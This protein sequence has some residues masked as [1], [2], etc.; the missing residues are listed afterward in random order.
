MVSLFD[1]DLPAEDQDD[2]ADLLDNLEG[3]S[4]PSEDAELDAIFREDLASI[5][6]SDEIATLDELDLEP[7]SSED[8]ELEA[9]LSES[10][11]TEEPDAEFAFPEITTGGEENPPHD[12]ELEAMF[13]DD[14]R[15]EEPDVEVS[16]IEEPD[17]EITPSEDIELDAVFSDDLLTEGLDVEMPPAEALES[18]ISAAPEPELEDIFSEPSFTEVAP[19]ADAELE[20]M[21]NDVASAKVT[22]TADLDVESLLITELDSEAPSSESDVEFAVDYD[23]SVADP[24]L[25]VISLEEPTAD[26][27]SSEVIFTEPPEME[28]TPTEE[29]MTET[30]SAESAPEEVVAIAP[31]DPPESSPASPTV[32][33]VV[34]AATPTQPPLLVPTVAS[35]GGELS[36]NTQ[37]WLKRPEAVVLILFVSLIMLWQMYLDFVEG[38][39]L[40]KPLSN[41]ELARRLGIT[42][43]TLSRRKD[44]IDFPAWTQDLDPDGIAWVHQNGVFVP[45]ID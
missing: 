38:T 44:R 19:A 23:R 26:R 1:E 17:A 3:E 22:P 6:P 11:L 27:V 25:E 35:P 39:D 2:R 20:S 41:R 31:P 21:F 40:D 7:S 8:A 33:V 29:F 37:D 30:S 34:D 18:A 15:T 14:L 5:E 43:N 36:P 45:R 10:T 9:A 42:R 32:T 28:P 12:A 4:S 24:A 13:S 16:F